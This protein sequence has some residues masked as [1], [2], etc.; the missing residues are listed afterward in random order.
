MS[1]MRQLSKTEWRIVVDMLLLLSIVVFPWWVTLIIAF[2]TLLYFRNFIEF[3]VVGLLIDLLYAPTPERHYFFSSSFYTVLTA[4]IF[5]IVTTLK[6][7]L[8]YYET[9]R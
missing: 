5:L 3:I 4:I 1:L 8:I 7:F 2:G 9:R 6:R